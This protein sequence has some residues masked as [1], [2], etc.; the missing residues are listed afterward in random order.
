MA[1]SATP[2]RVNDVT[3]T[4]VLTDLTMVL[5]EGIAAYPAHGRSIR[6]LS[7]IMQHEHFDGKGRFNRYD[8]SQVSFA[9]TQW[10]MCDQ[11]GTHMDAP[12]HASRDSGLTAEAIPLRFGIGPAIWLDCS[13]AAEAEGVTVQILEAALA[14][15]GAEVRAGDVV[16]LRTGA[17][18]RA[19]SDPVGYATTAVGLTKDAGE[20][21]R[22][23]A[24]KTVGIDCVTIESAQTAPT[25][26]VHTNFLNPATIG[27]EPDDVI[28]VIENLVGLDRIPAPR[29]TFVGLPLPLQGAAGSPIRAVA[30]T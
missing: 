26:D 27:R 21:L 13:A 24:I 20:W 11:V 6:E 4:E 10:V 16:L 19:V 1:S 28:A 5:R 2:E 9:I 8:G 3:T 17:S 15:A 14:A 12:W 18:D 30:I 7:P 29:F 22:A 23:A 25:A